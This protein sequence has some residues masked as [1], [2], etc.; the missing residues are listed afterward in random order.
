MSSPLL[1]P[2]R[3]QT[4]PTKS[5]LRISSETSVLLVQVLVPPFLG[6]ASSAAAAQ[7]AVHADSE[8]LLTVDWQASA[9]SQVEGYT[10]ALGIRPTRMQVVPSTQSQ[11]WA[12]PLLE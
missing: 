10:Q 1:N 9:A 12:A 5:L 8:Q 6:V 11:A 4:S 7:A 3:I 2:S